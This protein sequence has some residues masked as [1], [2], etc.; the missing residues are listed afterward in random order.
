MLMSAAP[1]VKPK[2]RLA[3]RLKGM[4][5]SAGLAGSGFRL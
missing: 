3:A 2:S 1:R 5:A 4:A